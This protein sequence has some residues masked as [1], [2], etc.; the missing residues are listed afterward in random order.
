MTRFHPNVPGKC[1]CIVLKLSRIKPPNCGTL[2]LAYT[3]T[4]SPP[5]KVC[6]NWHESHLCDRANLNILTDTGKH[7]K[8]WATA[9][10]EKKVPASKSSCM[11]M[12][13]QLIRIV[14]WQMLIYSGKTLAE[15]SLGLVLQ[16]HFLVNRVL[17]TW[18][19]HTSQISLLCYQF[20]GQHQEA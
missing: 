6:L 11:H 3:Y 4:F 16:Q 20:C 7:R 14:K 17:I 19:V 12:R 5:G 9:Y 13:T 1:P 10:S 18:S 2:I 15:Y 8:S